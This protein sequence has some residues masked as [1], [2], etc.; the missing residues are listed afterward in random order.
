MSTSETAIINQ[1]RI[2]DQVYDYLRTEI[3]EGRLSPGER[4]SPEELSERLKVSKMPIKEAIERLAGEGLLEVQSRRGTFVSR[5]DPQELAETFE[6]RCALEVL[7]GK[8]AVRHFAKADIDQLRQLIAAMEKSTAKS[9]VRAHLEQN[10]EFHELIV[11]RSGNGK[12]LETYRR[13]RTPIHLAGIH[14]RTDDWVARV[15]REQREHRAIVRALEQRDPAAVEQAIT[16][17]IMRA[18]GSLV[19]DVVR[20]VGA[21]A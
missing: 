13:L 8:L 2:S 1:A 10:A 3:V 5:L 12:L 4:I 16:S 19:E 7:A 11:L 6:V 9:D 21:I 15:A 17:H 14:S 20:V 18:S